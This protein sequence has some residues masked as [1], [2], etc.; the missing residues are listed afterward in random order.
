[1]AAGCAV[2]ASGPGGEVYVDSE[3]PPLQVDVATPI[4]GPGY[5]WIGGEWGWEGGRWAWHGGHWDRPPHPG[6]HWAAG[7]FENRGGR[8]VYHRGGWR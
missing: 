8:R 6:A 7:R 5:V 1:M 2:E 4:P 3:P